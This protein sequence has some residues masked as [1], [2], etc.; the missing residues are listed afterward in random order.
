MKKIKAN[1]FLKI[2]LIL[3]MTLGI[4]NITIPIIKMIAVNFITNL[5]TLMVSLFFGFAIMTSMIHLLKEAPKSIQPRK[6]MRPK[7]WY[8]Q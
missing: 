1:S 5:I 7:K 8:E 3:I 2:V 4:I 6:K